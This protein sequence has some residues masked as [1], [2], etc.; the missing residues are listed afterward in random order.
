MLIRKVLIIFGVGI[1]ML[2]L[3]IYLFQT[4]PP[5]DLSKINTLIVENKIEIDQETTLQ[6]TIQELV[7]SGEII[8]Y[9]STNLIIGAGIFFTGI[10]FLFTAIHLSVDKLFFRK[11]YESPSVFSA[12]RRAFLFCIC[13]ISMIYMKLNLLD[14]LTLLGIPV[15]YFL[16][17]VMITR[18][19]VARSQNSDTGINGPS[20]T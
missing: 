3:S 9:F 16:I 4:L 18:I 2:G 13:I 5:F 20:V 6:S 15:V 14:N 7:A 12:S 8:N 1:I 17:E 10:F 11:Y 19:I